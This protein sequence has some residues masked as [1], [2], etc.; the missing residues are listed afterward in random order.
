MIRP[1]ELEIVEGLRALRNHLQ[2]AGAR[3]AYRNTRRLI[4]RAFVFLDRFSLDELK[5][6]IGEVIEPAKW[7]ILLEID[8]IR[9]SAE[10]QAVI[11]RQ[12]AE[13]SPGVMIQ[14]CPSCGRQTLIRASAFGSLRLYCR[15][16]AKLDELGGT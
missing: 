11:R 14:Q 10:A 5:W 16:T 9:R 13:R 1:E 15:H 3:Y 7:A 12:E 4:R 2:H 8:E 6:R